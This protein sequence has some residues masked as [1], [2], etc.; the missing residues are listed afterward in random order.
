MT[1]HWIENE[2]TR[3]KFWAYVKNNLGLIKD[4]VHEALKVESVKD[5]KGTKEAA[6]SILNKFAADKDAQLAAAQRAQQAQERAATDVL[7]QDVVASLPS[8]PVWASTEAVDPSGFRWKVSIAAGLKPVLR[9]AAVEQVQEGVAEFAEWAA[10]HGWTPANGNGYRAQPTRPQV[11]VTD[12]HGTRPVS[13]APQPQAPSDGPP[14]P[15]APPPPPTS[16]GTPPASVEQTQGSGGNG[17]GE[18]MIEFVKITAPKGKATIE[19]WRP[20]RKYAEVYWALGGEAFLEQVGS[21]LAQAGW[22]VAHFDAI[23]AEYT[24]PLTVEWE[25]S[26]KNP[27]WKDITAVHLRQ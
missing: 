10:R 3:N 27:K 26:P 21:D 19:F 8:L 9:I 15:P 17:S 7:L 2:D 20:N 23:G 6:F 11:T 18:F 16:A 24:L 25:Q 22:T 5:Y 1:E 12:A 4:E 14:E 13:A